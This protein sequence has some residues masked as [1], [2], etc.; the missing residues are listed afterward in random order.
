M[1]NSVS[2]GFNSINNT[3]EIDVKEN[4][5]TR[6][7]WTDILLFIDILISSGSFEPEI[8]KLLRKLTLE[9][10][11]AIYIIY[12]N[13]SEED[14]EGNVTLYKKFIDTVNIFCKK[15]MKM[16]SPVESEIPNGNNSLTSKRNNDN[17]DIFNCEDDCYEEGN[18][19]NFIIPSKK[20]TNNHKLES[21]NPKLFN[22]KSYIKKHN[23]RKS[24]YMTL[25]KNNDNP[26]PNNLY[27]NDVDS[28][29]KMKNKN[30]NYYNSSNNNFIDLENYENE[31]TDNFEFANQKENQN[32][33]KETNNIN[34]KS[35]ENLKDFSS[36]GKMEY[37]INEN[38]FFKPSKISIDNI[39]S[40]LKLSTIKNKKTDTNIL[41]LSSSKTLDK[42]D[43]KN[44]IKSNNLDCF[45]KELSGEN[46]EIIELIPS[47]KNKRN[48]RKHKY[49]KKTK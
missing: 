22:S 15:V 12:T 24:K 10:N 19:L 2:V 47:E 8:S 43:L 30:D 44:A 26:E 36:M 7:Y 11:L 20:F 46:E 32:Q 49:L 1:G 25:N 29:D 31:E 17:I 9:R 14:N 18:Y 33:L 45:V 34:N 39:P 21:K 40:T 48:M 4:I 5:Y 13:C 37:I 38:D 28:K 41:E 23:L 6:D 27:V 42:N 35:Y 3:D 16:P